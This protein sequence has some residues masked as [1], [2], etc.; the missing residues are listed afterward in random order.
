MVFPQ[1]LWTKS[2]KTSQY[3]HYLTI[4]WPCKERWGVLTNFNPI[5]L[6]ILMPSLV[7]EIHS[8]VL[9]KNIFQRTPHFHYLVI[10]PRKG[11]WSFI[12]MTWILSWGRPSFEFIWIPF[13]TGYFVLSLITIGLVV[14]ESKMLTT[15]KFRSKT[16]HKTFAQVS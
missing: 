3:F 5:Y 6:M 1:W 15:D 10:S 7:V 2:Q 8:L 11:V 9:E 12:Q 16:A 14:L 13:T 4:F